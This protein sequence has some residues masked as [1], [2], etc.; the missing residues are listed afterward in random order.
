MRV[1]D[2]MT[3]SVVT[4]TPATPV[5]DAAVVLAGHGITLLPVIDADR[6]VGIITRGTWYASSPATMR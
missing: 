5:K 3:R 6:L 1:R 2:L 4:T